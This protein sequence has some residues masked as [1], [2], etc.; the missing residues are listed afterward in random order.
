MMYERD[1]FNYTLVK[2]R[3]EVNESKK[4]VTITIWYI[5]TNVFV[6]AAY[7]VKF[8]RWYICKH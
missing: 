7:N 4:C 2:T 5:I 1:Y 3:L 6:T 8:N